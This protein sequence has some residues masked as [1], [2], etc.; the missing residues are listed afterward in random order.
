MTGFLS[1]LHSFHP[2]EDSMEIE[3][4]SE[5]LNFFYEFNQFLLG[6]W[7]AEEGGSNEGLNF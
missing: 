6:S 1:F 2:S 5:G 4:P 7:K 3:N